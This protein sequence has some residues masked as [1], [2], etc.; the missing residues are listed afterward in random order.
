MAR[1]VFAKRVSQMLIRLDL[2]IG[3]NHDESEYHWVRI[4]FEYVKLFYN[5]GTDKY[6]MYS[7]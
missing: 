7:A 6:R 5:E 3:P 2:P 4:I 1:K